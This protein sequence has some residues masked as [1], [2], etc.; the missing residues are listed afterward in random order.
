M[1]LGEG[2]TG[3]RGREGPCPRDAV[4]GLGLWP[5]PHGS[6]AASL[7]GGC[8]SGAGQGRVSRVGSP[9]PTMPSHSRACSSGNLQ[10]LGFSRELGVGA[11]LSFSCQDCLGWLAGIPAILRQGERKGVKG[12][13]QHPGLPCQGRWGRSSSVQGAPCHQPAPTPSSQTL[14]GQ[15]R[16]TRHVTKCPTVTLPDAPGPH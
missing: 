10:L 12:S 6:L 9:L 3:T 8:E 7:A 15:H 16:V 1:C 13:L 4:A 5:L 14:W 2:C 11:A